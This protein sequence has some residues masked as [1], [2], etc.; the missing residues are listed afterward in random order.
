MLLLNYVDRSL[1]LNDIKTIYVENRNRTEP[2]F[3]FNRARTV[4]VGEL[5]F[6]DGPITRISLFLFL[7]VAVFTYFAKDRRFVFLVV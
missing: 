4:I 1:G 3:L 5:I 2:V 7:W 6:A